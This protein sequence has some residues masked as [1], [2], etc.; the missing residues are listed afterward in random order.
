[1]NALCW[2]EAR[3]V[4]DVF[5]GAVVLFAASFPLA[6]IGVAMQGLNPFPWISA[7]AGG[8]VLNQYTMVLTA[9]LLGAA[10]F[11][12][13]K[14]E[15]SHHFLASLPLSHARQTGA[16]VFVTLATWTALW[17]INAAIFATVVLATGQGLEPLREFLPRIIGVLALSFA[18]LGLAQLAGCFVAS[19]TGAAFMAAAALLV[20]A[21]ARWI[22]PG[23]DIFFTPVFLALLLTVGAV[24]M[25]LASQS[26]GRFL[27]MRP[28]G[29]TGNFQGGR[30]YWM[31]DNALGA[32]I[33]KDLRRLHVPL[34]AGTTLLVLPFIAA[35]GHALLAGEGAAGLRTASLL[36]MA[37]GWIVLPLW[38]GT[39]LA[40]E[41]A[42]NTHLFLAGLPISPRRILGARLA[43]AALPA[44]LAGA[45][46]VAVFLIAQSQFPDEPMLVAGLS[47]DEFNRSHFLGG[48]VA[49]A[50]ALPVTFGAAWYFAARLRRPVLAI[51]LG[52]VTGP[53]AMAT[54]AVSGGPGGLLATYLPPLGAVAFH[55]A[56]LFVVSAGLIALGAR[57]AQRDGLV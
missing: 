47:W 9:A 1:M 21:V 20:V 4:S 48:A 13:E 35:G 51:V 45:V 46:C 49:Y 44:L 14:E 56:S 54:W 7:L 27:R 53:V 15:G 11:A 24:A 31:P 25:L 18:A 5:V 57:Q 40:G 33:W 28:K 42:T 19:V 10:A 17:A 29:A 52:V 30:L 43:A 6:C 23:D 2:K 8:C 37:L 3:L 32:L 26:Y 50:C 34:Y 38:C 41:W 36:A 55:G 39:S 16:K 12:R 22:V